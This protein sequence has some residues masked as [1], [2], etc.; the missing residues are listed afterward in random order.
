MK[1][2]QIVSGIFAALHGHS[3]ILLEPLGLSRKP[4][5]GVPHCRKTCNNAGRVFLRSATMRRCK[6]SVF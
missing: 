3:F 2:A 6:M 5:N 1:R 4:A